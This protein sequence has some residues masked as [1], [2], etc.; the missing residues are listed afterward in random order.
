M[1]FFY[2]VKKDEIF[3]YKTKFIENYYLYIIFGIYW[4]S[5]HIEMPAK[6]ICSFLLVWRELY[7][8]SSLY[9]IF[10]YLDK[11]ISL[12]CMMLV[13]SDVFWFQLRC[14]CRCLCVCFVLVIFFMVK[15]SVSYKDLKYV[16]IWTTIWLFLTNFKSALF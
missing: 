13:V 16:Q 8:T 1:K 15:T 9:F 6:R 7:N 14:Y 10:Y 11:V 4:D 12:A 5:E 3:L 2:F